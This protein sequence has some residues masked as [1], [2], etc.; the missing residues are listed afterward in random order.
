MSP[1]CIIISLSSHAP[2]FLVHCVLIRR[3]LLAARCFVRYEPDKP[4]CNEQSG[5]N[6]DPSPPMGCPTPCAA[7]RAP[8]DQPL[9]P[10]TSRATNTDFPRLAA[11]GGLPGAAPP[12][13]CPTHHHDASA[14]A[15][16]AVLLSSPSN[17]EQQ[18][19]LCS[20]PF[21]SSSLRDTHEGPGPGHAT[22]RAKHHWGTH[23]QPRPHGA[24]LP[25]VI[26]ALKLPPSLTCN[27]DGGID[28]KDFTVEE[29][30][31]LT[32]LVLGGEGPHREPWLVLHPSPQIPESVP[33]ATL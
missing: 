3:Q 28:R 14:R 6:C 32:V 10:F 16:S 12:A 27:E 13:A 17:W 18:R 19:E 1:N 21:P 26:K 31:P 30:Q 29:E 7:P 4:R 2:D 22:W 5:T 15:T 23:W 33:S 25:H 8:P 20:F 24:T 11:P 9:P